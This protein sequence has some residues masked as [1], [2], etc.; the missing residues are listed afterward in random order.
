M[1]DYQLLMTLKGNNIKFVL[2]FGGQT[3]GVK[4]VTFDEL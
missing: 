4:D 2:L 1:A 3:F